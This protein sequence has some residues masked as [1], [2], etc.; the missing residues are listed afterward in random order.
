MRKANF[1]SFPSNSP[2]KAGA[3]FKPYLGVKS[4]LRKKMDYYGA[5]SAIIS[6]SLLINGE[7]RCITEEDTQYYGA[8]HLI[9][10]TTFDSMLLIPQI[11]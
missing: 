7:L 3:V 2:G 10:A 8:S 11:T 6:T 4:K 5:Y 9:F 1:T